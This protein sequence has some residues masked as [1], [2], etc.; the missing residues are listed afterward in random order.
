MAMAEKGGRLKYEAAALCA[1]VKAKYSW[2]LADGLPDDDED[3]P[4][5]VE[6]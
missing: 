2:D 6:Q 4:V 3:Q 5:I 1:V